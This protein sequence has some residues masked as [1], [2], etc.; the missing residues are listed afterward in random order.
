MD[1]RRTL[2]CLALWL[3]LAAQPVGAQDVSGWQSLD[4]G[5]MDTTYIGS[6][7][8][9]QAG[10]TVATSGPVQVSGWFVDTSAQGWAGADAVQVVHGDSVLAQ[11]TIGGNRPD[12]AATFGNAFWSTSGFAATFDAA[13]L[14]TGLTTLSVQLHTPSKG[15]LARDLTLTIGTAEIL[16]PAPAAQGPLPQ[17]TVLTPAPAEAVST[18]NRRYVISG[19]AR[20][21]SQSQGGIDSVEVWLNGEANTDSA[22]LL[23]MPDVGADGTWSLEFDPAQFE[24]AD[25]NLYVY[26]RS[27]LSGK[28]RLVVVHFQITSRR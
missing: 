20:D 13:R 16:A 3:A 8:A 25:A 6:I 14:P 24:P 9:P 22:T 10:A 23:G 19:S 11:G 5:Q 15:W 7:D 2:A 4:T 21:P 28:R 26:A 12:V 17:V 1:V 18:S 27:A